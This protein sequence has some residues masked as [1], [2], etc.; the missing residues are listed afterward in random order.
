MDKEECYLAE[1]LLEV[2]IGRHKKTYGS[3]EP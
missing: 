3:K 1:L 2:D